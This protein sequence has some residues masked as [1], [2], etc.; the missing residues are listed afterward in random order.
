MY[1]TEPSKAKGS[2]KE[3]F[4]ESG[5]GMWQFLLLAQVRIFYLIL[6]NLNNKFLDLTLY[7]KYNL[8]LK[9]FCSLCKKSAVQVK[10]LFILRVEKFLTSSIM[11]KIITFK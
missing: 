8:L 3:V 7:V 10:L 1:S 2:Y 6:Y 11:A 4:D 5:F 9:D